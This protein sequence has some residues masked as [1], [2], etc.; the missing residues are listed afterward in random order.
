MKYY[1]EIIGF[2]AYWLVVEATADFEDDDVSGWK[3]AIKYIPLAVCVRI[4]SFPLI[5]WWFIKE[6]RNARSKAT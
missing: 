2:L 1:E 6:R 4:L 3:L 5:L